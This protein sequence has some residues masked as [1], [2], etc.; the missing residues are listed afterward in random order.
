L[1]QSGVAVEKLVAWTDL[2]R[3]Q[4]RWPRFAPCFWA[5]T[6]DQEYPFQAPDDWLLYAVTDDPC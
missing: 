4:G 5:L 2:M 6:W 3:A 1:S